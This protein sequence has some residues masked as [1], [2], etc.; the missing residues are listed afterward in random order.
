MVLELGLDIISRNIGNVVMG[1]GQGV[2][3]NSLC[4]ENGVSWIAVL[5]LKQCYKHC[6]QLD[7]SCC[8]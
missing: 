2:S 6:L 8:N 1:C 3:R 5:W 4:M 7:F